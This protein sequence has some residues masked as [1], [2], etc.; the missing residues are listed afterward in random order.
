MIGLAKAARNQT[1]LIL[2]VSINKKPSDIKTDPVNHHPTA[3]EDLFNL[4]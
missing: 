1:D 2:T 3:L 4:Y